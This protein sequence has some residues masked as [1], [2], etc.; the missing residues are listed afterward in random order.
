MLV[1]DRAV[2][3]V[4]IWRGRRGQQSARG[5]VWAKDRRRD[6]R[7]RRR[8]RRRRR[9]RRQAGTARTLWMVT[10][11]RAYSA[12]SVCWSSVRCLLPAYGLA[13]SALG[14]PGAAGRVA[15][16]AMAGGV[17]ASSQ[18]MCWFRR[19]RRA[20]QGSGGGHVTADDVRV[21]PLREGASERARVGGRRRR[22]AAGLRKRRRRRGA[23]VIRRAGCCRG[24]RA[25]D[26]L[27][28]MWM[29]P[30]HRP[31]QQTDGG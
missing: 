1:A 15:S 30:A 19:G 6:R 29:R 31:M 16:E 3:R 27:C 9:R 25:V 5:C 28:W 17:V 4:A 7:R 13:A 24:P 20:G 12:R 14:S 2:A 26:G 8:G 18:D 11:R 22:G 10:A 23:G 21:A